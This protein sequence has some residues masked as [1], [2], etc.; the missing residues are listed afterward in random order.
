MVPLL[1]QIFLSQYNPNLQGGAPTWSFPLVKGAYLDAGVSMARVENLE[2]QL[3]YLIHKLKTTY[4]STVDYQNDWKL[5][6]IFIGANNLCNACVDNG[7]HWDSS[8]AY[9]E[10]HLDKVLGLVRKTIP[11]V[12]VNLIT[13]F[14]ISGVYYAGKTSEYCTIFHDLWKSEC[15]CVETGKKWDLQT[16]DDFT[17][18]YNKISEKLAKKYA[19]LNDPNYTVVV[20]PGLSGIDLP[21]FPDPLAYLSDLDCFHL[22]LCANEAFSYQIWNNMQ[23]PVGQKST[24]PD[25]QNLKLKCP[26]Q[27]TYLQ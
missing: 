15:T 8:P 21:K 1:L 19:G 5:L 3:A 20:Q 26:N 10:S 12:F 4:A 24:T 6:T 27:N 11:R 14:N 22:S 9:F 17:V 2:D 16:M 18:A 13:I 23:T 25:I 7:H